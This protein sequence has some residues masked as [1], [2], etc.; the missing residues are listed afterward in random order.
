MEFLFVKYLFFLLL[1]QKNFI[2]SKT[3]FIDNQSKFLV[4]SG[5]SASNN[6]DEW[7]IHLDG[8]LN[9]AHEFAKLHDLMLIGKVRVH[10]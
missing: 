8:D 3:V 6:I 2:Y 9:Y 4:N 1:I 5:V 7:V 10:N